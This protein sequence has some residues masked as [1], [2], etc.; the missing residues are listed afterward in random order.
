[1]TFKVLPIAFAAGM[2][3]ASA[4][5]A[6]ASSETL[7]PQK[8]MEICIDQLGIY[9]PITLTLKSDAEPVP[10]DAFD[11]GPD[12]QL[13]PGQISALHQCYDQKMAM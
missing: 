8:A 6:L 9:D 12:A 2:A 13:E 7:T 10:F 4:L 11:F 1:M 3:L 5:P